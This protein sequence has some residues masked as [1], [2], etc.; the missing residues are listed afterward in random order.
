VVL[1]DRYGMRSLERQG[2]E[3]GKREVFGGLRG[4]TRRQVHIPIYCRSRELHGL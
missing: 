1:W 2:R 3:D 4:K